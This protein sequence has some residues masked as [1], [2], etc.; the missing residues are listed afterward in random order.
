MRPFLMNL[1]GN[2]GSKNNSINSN[3]AGRSRIQDTEGVSSRLHER[4][5]VDEVWP[6]VEAH[7][8][9]AAHIIRSG[10]TE[11]VDRLRDARHRMNW[12]AVIYSAC[13]GQP[14]RSCEIYHRL[15]LFLLN[16]LEVNVLRPFLHHGATGCAPSS[17]LCQQFALQFKLFM[18]FRRVVLSC[19]GYL[20]QYYTAKFHLDPVTAL[21][22][23]MFYAV[24]Y[25]PIRAVLAKEIMELANEART[26]HHHGDTVSQAG[27]DVRQA[28]AAISEIL[29]TVR[30]YSS[31]SGSAAPIGVAAGAATTSATT[32]GCGGGGG[33]GGPCDAGMQAARTHKGTDGYHASDREEYSG[34][35][36]GGEGHNTL[37]GIIAEVDQLQMFSSG[38]N[39]QVTETSAVAGCVSLEGIR[40]LRERLE[41][42]SFAD[43][44][45]GP[46]VI[47]RGV[48]SNGNHTAAGSGGGRDTTGRW[49]SDPAQVVIVNIVEPLHTL[50]FAYFGVQFVQAAE[51]YYREQRAL[52][53]ARP[54]G[55]RGYMAWVQQ[56]RDVERSLVKDVSVS[57][58]HCVLRER[59][60]QVLLV[61]VHRLIILDEELGFRAQLD[62]WA[63][64]RGLGS[65]IFLQASSSFTSSST[66]PSAVVSA[67][68]T[69]FSAT[70]APPAVVS[71]TYDGERTQP[72]N[73]WAQLSVDELAHK[74]KVFATN[75]F[76]TQDA[77]CCVLLASEFAS[78]VVT[79]TTE[80]FTAYISRVEAVQQQQ[81]QQQR[82]EQQHGFS[83]LIDVKPGVAA[84]RKRPVSGDVLP[85]A[86][87]TPAANPTLQDVAMALIAGL[88]DAAQHFGGLVREQFN[89]HPSMQ[90]AMCDAFREILN[91]ERWG[92]LGVRGRTTV[93]AELPSVLLNHDAARRTLAVM[94][95]LAVLRGAREIA[96]PQL[97][98]AYCDQLCRREMGSVTEGSED[99]GIH[100]AYLAALLDDKDVFLEHYKLLLARRLLLLLPSQRNV[101][102]ER[103]LV[104]KLQESLGRTLTH[105]LVAMLH[106]CESTANISDSFRETEAHNAL[107][108]KM[109]VQVL[110]AVHWPA[111]RV[112]QLTPCASLGAGMQAF[113]AFYAEVH[114]SRTLHW[115]HT[116]G[117]AMLHAVFPRGTKEVIA[118][119]LQAHILLLVS[120]ACNAGRSTAA[121]SET[122]DE[123]SVVVASE[124]R[125]AVRRR[126]VAGR[127]IA[128]VMG[129]EFADLRVHLAPLVQHKGFNLLTR[130]EP[131][132]DAS[133]SPASAGAMVEAPLLPD[134]EFAL[135]VEFTHKLRKFK[136]PIARP[137]PAQA[138]GDKSRSSAEDGAESVLS[139]AIEDTRRLQIDAA[140]IRIMKSR[141]SL[142]YYELLDA[143]VQQ[144]SRLFAPSS[145][146]VKAQVEDLVGRGFLQ[147]SEGDASVFEYVA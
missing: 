50:I 92:Q 27:E 79:D 51:T 76:N 75:F 125:G 131:R 110:T 97:L 104:H 71:N 60:H 98:A 111:Y 84:G 115:I 56:C 47:G 55:R 105:G 61:E 145:R 85:N 88:V 5:S 7:L 73:F 46:M 36:S 70:P 69:D 1:S 77:A 109:R 143:T 54:E 121:A 132:R 31:A 127:S 41:N 82:H 52:Q 94:K 37:D 117:S 6:L 42:R 90:A 25:E 35:G 16:D 38:Q 93:G 113:A 137:R 144:L 147:R 65:A 4:P 53:I 129:I 11:L 20:D 119:T 114:P 3:G 34:G 101:D 124:Q 106:D 32:S 81:Q 102:G 87:A 142:R 45:A 18:A 83:S 26:A 48:S 23:K 44:M 130:V 12:Y 2:R 91:P 30:A 62:A 29:T 57:L 140:I 28:L 22:V 116:L 24:V 39:S 86:A 126:A 138:A 33:G 134:D 14:Q 108:A 43:L 74:M 141:R 17:S 100:I 118:N 99:R 59:L 9:H 96:T 95:R 21:C 58:F 64:H 40:L 128:S 80:L 136:L 13:S 15:A 72:E 19:F 67:L 66:Y 135:N 139:A 146:S 49:A 68:T 107:P 112:V 8:V 103:V 122:A 10:S 78:K 120:D 123:A 89:A 133:M 63:R